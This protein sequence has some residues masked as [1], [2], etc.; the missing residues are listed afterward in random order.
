MQE[1]SYLKEPTN[2]PSRFTIMLD[3]QHPDIW[4]PLVS[5]GRLRAD[6]WHRF[7]K[8]EHHDP[9]THILYSHYPNGGIHGLK[10]YGVGAAS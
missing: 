9:V 5:F 8:M 1:K 2:D 10:A 7:R 4:K 6:T 3:N